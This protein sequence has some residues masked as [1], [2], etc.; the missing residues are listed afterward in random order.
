MQGVVPA[1]GKGTRLRPLTADRPK[2]LV[3]VDGQPILTHCFETLREAGVSAFIVVIGYKGQQIVEYYGES[4]RD[5]P[6]TYVEQSDQLGLGHAVAQAEPYVTDAF[7]VLNGDNVF[8]SDIH[9]IVE[10][11]SNPAVDAAMLV[12]EVSRDTARTTG[13][14]ETNSDDRVTSV[15][16]KPNEPSSTLVSAGC[17]FLPPAVFHALALVR[18]SDRDEYELTDAVDLLVEAG[19]RVDAITFDGERININTQSDLESAEQLV[20]SDRS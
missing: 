14:V 17:W 9:H 18:P 19:W 2:A 5:I 10:R 6:I 8:G 13:V 1:A 16:E 11:A 20:A 7:V 4:Y 15:E 3:E 12:E